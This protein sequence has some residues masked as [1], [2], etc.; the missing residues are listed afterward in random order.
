MAKLIYV[1][2]VSLDGYIE[3]EHGNF[4]FGPTDDE[5]FAFFTHLLRPVSTYL[6][7][8]RLYNAMAVWE[9]DTALGGRSE[10]FA[11]FANV[12]KA[13]S[14]IF[15]STTLDAVSTSNSRLE[16]HFDADLVRDLKA[17]AS[18]DLT[19]GARLSRGTRSRRNGR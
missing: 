2:N 14:K 18:G 4:D 6:Y 7:G 3:D 12:W 10:L 17:S 11:G 13:A 1:T 19:V 16:R 15:Y 9:T 8:R 5:L